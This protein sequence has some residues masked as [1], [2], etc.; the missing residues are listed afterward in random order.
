MKKFI[1]KTAA[2]SLSVLGILS[3]MPSAFCVPPKLDSNIVFSIT[4][5]NIKRVEESYKVETILKKYED[6]IKQYNLSPSEI[7]SNCL[8]NI[9]HMGG[10]RVGGFDEGAN[11]IKKMIY[12]P[13]SFDMNSFWKILRVNGII[14][15]N[16]E[17]SEKWEHKVERDSF[18][19][20]QVA[21]ICGDNKI[22]FL[23]DISNLK[24]HADIRNSEP[25]VVINPFLRDFYTP[26]VSH[27]EDLEDSEIPLFDV[28]IEESSTDDKIL[29]K[30]SIPRSATSIGNGE[31]YNFR[32]LEKVFIPDSVNSI[33]EDGFKNCVK[34]K[35]I[36]IPSS[37]KDIGKHAFEN[38][39]DLK[40]I[41]IP[42]FVSDIKEY[43]FYKCLELEN[44]H[45]PISVR[46]LE[47]HSFEDCISL[48][49]I[50]I[51]DSASIGESCFKGCINLRKIFIPDSIMSIGK[52]AF[53]GCLKL[54]EI[55]ISN[56]VREIKEG[57]FSGCGELE[58]VHLPIFA[59]SIGGYAFKCCLALKEIFIPSTV[60]NIGEKA[61]YNCQN[62]SRI[63]IPCGVT[64]IGDDAFKDCINLKSIIFNGK[65]YDSVESFMEAFKDY[66]TSQEQQM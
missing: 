1:K 42:N 5:G 56:S 40:E 6:I 38:C 16:K 31:F 13:G 19:N 34:L 25:E 33:G 29:K 47:G 11:P 21:F 24:C 7:Y 28:E 32:D 65:E 57:T 22:I 8:V 43:T 20:I 51:P 41:S 26:E 60:T 14:N 17:Y 39:F 46:N 4:K 27:L 55:I 52:N 49:E 45:I 23:F 63:H 3:V 36:S 2:A 64:T 35:K 18:N 10:Y 54:K 30:V 48:K 37:V 44:V 66:R 9:P 15:E 53:E 61:F 50:N 12:L 62:L 58:K 59:T